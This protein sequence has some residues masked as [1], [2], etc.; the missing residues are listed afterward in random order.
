MIL[1]KMGS[2][3]VAKPPENALFAFS[4]AT[5]SHRFQLKSLY[6]VRTF[7]VNAGVH[8][9]THWANDDVLLF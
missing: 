2:S 9:L 6:L 7:F 5:R 4:G 8:D 1:L 3:V